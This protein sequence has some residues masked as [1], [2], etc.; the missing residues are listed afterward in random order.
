MNDPEVY[1]LHHFTAIS[2]DPTENAKFY[3]NVL[4]MRM[5]KKTV[6][7]DAPQVYHLFY[8]DYE[9]TP[10]SSVTFFPDMADQQGEQGAGQVTELG[11]RI[12]QGSLDYWRERL[13]DHEIDFQEEEWHGYQTLSLEDDSGIPLRLVVEGS[14]DFTTWEDSKV[15][16]EHQVRGMHHVE[17]SVQDS[18]NTRELL[19]IMS[20]EEVEDGFFE[21][22]DGSK[23]VINETDKRGRMGT[24]TVHHI[25]F[26][27]QDEQESD[28][29]RDKLQRHGMRPSPLVNRKYFSSIYFREPGGVLFEFATM[30]EG[31]TA[32]ES[33]EDLGSSLVLPENLEDQREK[34]ESVLPEF[35]EEEIR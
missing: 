31:Y 34:I 5:V 23:V 35:R 12:P 18:T 26:K 29:W 9:G 13:E 33:L 11:L 3:V 24:G 30:G 28:K 7:H 25:A 10:G 27:V 6:N 16:E 15:P 2:G 32:D 20:L 17:L 19:N 22:E 21:A 8:G 4:G 1:G 14:E